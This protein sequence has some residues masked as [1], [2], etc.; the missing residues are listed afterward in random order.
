MEHQGLNLNYKVHLH[1][2][3]GL[4]ELLVQYRALLAQGANKKMKL[5]VLGMLQGYLEHKGLVQID[6]PWNNLVEPT[7]AAGAPQEIGD[8]SRMK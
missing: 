7:P 4:Q 1:Y 3:L 8:H 2:H 6:N 5:N